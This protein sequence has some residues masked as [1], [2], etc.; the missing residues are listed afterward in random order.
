MIE[1]RRKLRNRL[2]EARNPARRKDLKDKLERINSKINKLTPDN[3]EEPD[4]DDPE[5]TGYEIND[6]SDRPKR[7]RKVKAANTE[8]SDNNRKRPM[9]D[10]DD[11]DDDIVVD[12]DSEPETSPRRKLRRRKKKL[13][14]PNEVEQ[15]DDDPT[16]SAD[17]DRDDDDD[18][19]GADVN[20]DTLFDD[21]RKLRNRLPEAKNPQRRKQLKEK[22]ERIKS[23]MIQDNDMVNEP[24]DDR[25]NQD[26]RKDINYGNSEPTNKPDDKQDDDPDNHRG[27]RRKNAPRTRFPDNQN[28]LLNKRNK[29]RKRLSE[30][31]NAGRKDDLKDKIDTI[32]SKLLDLTEKER[33]RERRPND[34]KRTSPNDEEDEEDPDDLDETNPIQSLLDKRKQFRNRLSEAKNANRREDLKDKID[35]IDRK[36]ADLTEEQKPKRIRRPNERRPSSPD[37]EGE[38]DDPEDMNKDPVESL[39]D[40]RRKLQ[41]RLSEAKNADRRE[42]LKDKMDN[43]NSKISERGLEDEVVDKKRDRKNDPEMEGEDKERGKTA[44]KKKNN[45]KKDNG[46]SSNRR[47]RQETSPPDRDE[48]EIEELNDKKAKLENRLSDA[49][50]PER[51][52][53]LED[54]IDGI[55]QK[56]SDILV[57]K[58]DRLRNRLSESKNPSRRRDLKDKINTVNAKLQDLDVYNGRKYKIGNRADRKRNSRVKDNDDKDRANGEDL[59]NTKDE[60]SDGKTRRRQR[61]KKTEDKGNDRNRK[62]GREKNNDRGKSDSD[63]RMNTKHGMMYR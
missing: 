56:I 51:R 21:R 58:R 33:P 4:T 41:N 9:A 40:K 45:R 25:T 38:Q 55:N 6:V 32:D 24:E 16:D 27:G 18:D 11:D 17:V 36:L 8:T 46:K 42:D 52:Q 60:P 48:S 35:T 22:L 5:S 28:S 53:D 3:V 13:N 30:A 61:K 29:I 10:D 26:S 31:K 12:D 37:D 43:L 15:N 14:K 62:D 1:K 19:N 47:N 20:D 54:K 50:N 49:K 2:S 7:R 44:I 59:P 39:L 34:S 63:E 23:L 57:D